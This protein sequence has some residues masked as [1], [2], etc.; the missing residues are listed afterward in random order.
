MAAWQV[1]H[2]CCRHHIQCQSTYLHTYL[3]CWQAYINFGYNT[4]LLYLQMSTVM[5]G[6]IQGSITG[7]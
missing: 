7:T 5:H 3:S 6:H 4:N 2:I 1:R